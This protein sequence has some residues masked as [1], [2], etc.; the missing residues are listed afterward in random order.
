MHGNGV[1]GCGFGVIRSEN[2][3]LRDLRGVPDTKGVVLVWWRLPEWLVSDV[4]KYI[5]GIVFYF[6]EMF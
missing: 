6:F 2:V 5:L 4:E 1:F 3:C